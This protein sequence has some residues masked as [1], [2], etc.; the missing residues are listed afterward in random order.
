MKV[1]FLCKG[2]CIYPRSRSIRLAAPANMAMQA[3]NNTNNNRRTQKN[4]LGQTLNVSSS[5]TVYY[6]N[7]SLSQRKC[8]SIVSKKITVTHPWPI[9]MRMHVRAE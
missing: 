9:D 1:N 5:A 4:N 7:V 6:L 3:N 8:E 2:C